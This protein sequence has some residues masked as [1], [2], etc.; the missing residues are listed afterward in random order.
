ML[1]T[2]LNQKNSSAVVPKYEIQLNMQINDY[3]K[4]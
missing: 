2:V 1:F 3:N 4:I